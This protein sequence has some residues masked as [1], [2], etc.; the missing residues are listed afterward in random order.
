[1]YLFQEIYET[2]TDVTKTLSIAVG[3]L[4]DLMTFNKIESGMMKLTKDDVPI[5]SYVNDVVN[6]FAAES[7]AKG[8]EIEVRDID[9]K[10][11]RKGSTLNPR[12]ELLILSMNKSIT[13]S[14]NE[15]KAVDQGRARWVAA[16]RRLVP[17]HPFIPVILSRQTTITITKNKSPY[18]LIHVVY[19]LTHFTNK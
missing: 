17:I 14:T 4:A 11:G 18:Q 8:I 2:A 19:T 9:C 15:E 13:S 1:M 16:T 5:Q 6:T 3:I 12:N 7:R 10:T